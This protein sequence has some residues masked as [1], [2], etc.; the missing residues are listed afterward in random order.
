[1][2]APVVKELSCPSCGATALVRVVPGSDGHRW[3]CPHCHK[4]QTSDKV[5]V[6]AAPEKS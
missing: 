1:M 6:E 5:T 2:N 4:L 3:H